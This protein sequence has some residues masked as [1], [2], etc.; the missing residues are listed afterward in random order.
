MAVTLKKTF[1][2]DAPP[3]PCPS[4]TCFKYTVSHHVS[5]LS[6]PLDSFTK[7]HTISPFHIPACGSDIQK[8]MLEVSN[9]Q[10]H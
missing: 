5:T 3:T 2:L 9:A 10:S 8:I 7:Q 6:L 4:F 1:I